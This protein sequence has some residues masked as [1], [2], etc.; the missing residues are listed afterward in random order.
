MST[1]TEEIIVDPIICDKLSYTLK[2]GQEN[3]DILKKKIEQLIEKGYARKVYKGSYYTSI[4][5]LLGAF[6]EYKPL[7]QIEPKLQDTAY[8]RVEYNPDKLGI[9]NFEL[10]QKL[11]NL[12]KHIG[13]Y[14]YI[15]LNATCTRFDATVDIHHI[16]INNLLFYY[17]KKTISKAYFKSGKILNY[18]DH[19]I[20]S[21]Y[22]GS[23]AGKMQV[24][25]YDKVLQMKKYKLEN[26]LMDIKIP[27]HDITRIEIRHKK[28]L[29]LVD[30]MKVNNQFK[31]I[32]VVLLKVANKIKDWR[33]NMIVRLSCHEG[34]NNALLAVPNDHRLKFRTQIIE[35]TA[36]EWWKPDLIWMD[37]SNT[38]KAL[39]F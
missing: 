36:P 38:V 28:R 2:I 25:I 10:K 32:K 6:D 3:R 22:L 16:N 20:T 12:L 21:Y 33:T 5:L 35:D 34:L 15:L 31:P 19:L 26:P 18:E 4:H 17:P 9:Y 1:F 27:D 39:L 8:M 30:I 14:K 37:W 13:G 11:N 29:S 23:D 24:C 7:I